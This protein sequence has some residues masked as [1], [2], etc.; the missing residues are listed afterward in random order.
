MYLIITIV[1]IRFHIK[2]KFNGEDLGIMRAV[3]TLKHTKRWG[4]F[5]KK[6]NYRLYMNR[7]LYLKLKIV[8]SEDNLLLVKFTPLT[9]A[10]TRKKY[11]SFTY[12]P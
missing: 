8:L 7:N 2:K 3:L 10:L 12:T 11:E 1:L 5:K 9:Y 4:N 6:P